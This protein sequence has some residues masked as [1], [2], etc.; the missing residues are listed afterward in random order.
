MFNIILDAG[1]NENSFGESYIHNGAGEYSSSG[2]NGNSDREF[3]PMYVVKTWSR[4]H[5]GEG[6][7]CII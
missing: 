5:I 4:R 7:L 1:E 3:I 2:A 6:T